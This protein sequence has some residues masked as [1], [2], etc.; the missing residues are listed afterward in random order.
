MLQNSFLKLCSF[1]YSLLFL[2]YQQKTPFREALT[3]ACTMSTPSSPTGI[4]W[5]VNLNSHQSKLA[6]QL[7][8][9][10][11]PI[12][13]DLWSICV[14]SL[15]PDPSCPCFSLAAGIDALAHRPATGCGRLWVRPG[16][17]ATIHYHKCRQ[18]QA[19]FERVVRKGWQ[20]PFWALLQSLGEQQEGQTSAQGTGQSR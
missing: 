10:Q 15:G 13:T 17:I 8:P 6:L 18:R 1:F 14:R 2:P 16:K 4:S 20:V 5:E 19:S 7:L 12:L 9:L 11:S 3:H